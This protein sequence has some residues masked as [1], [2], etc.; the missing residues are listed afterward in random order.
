MSAGP[1][2]RRVMRKGHEGGSF[3]LLDF[4]P[5]FWSSKIREE[6][7]HFACF[8]VKQKVG[9]KKSITSIPHRDP[10]YIIIVTSP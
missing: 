1:T 9:K 10:F 7:H 8:F 4:L 6:R 5:T 3:V 2:K